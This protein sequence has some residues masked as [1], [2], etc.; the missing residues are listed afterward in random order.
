MKKELENLIEAAQDFTEYQ[1]IGN[2]AKLNCA[3]EM[4]QNAVKN[5]GV[6]AVVMPSIYGIFERQTG[7]AFGY[8]HD[9][10]VADRI[11]EVE[12][13][14]RWYVDKLDINK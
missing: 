14:D 7:E 2:G 13:G 1:S 11:C 10:N 5:N 6:L 8:Y 9:K 4:A 3:I 12:C